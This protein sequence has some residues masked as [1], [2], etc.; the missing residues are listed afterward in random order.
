MRSWIDQMKPQA[1]P[2]PQPLPVDTAFGHVQKIIGDNCMMCHANFTGFSESDFVTNKLVMPGNASQSELYAKLIGSNVGGAIKADM[3]LK[4][5]PLSTDQLLDV[6]D[7]I[8][9]MPAPTPTATPIPSA[10]PS[11]TPSASPVSSPSPSPSP[12]ASSGTLTAAQRTSAA[13]LVISTNCAFCHGDAQTATS[14]VFNGKAVPVFAG[15]TTD[16]QFVSSGIINAGDPTRSWLIRSL[17]NFGDINTMPQ[18]SS[19]LST[20]DA[21]TLKTWI[22]G[23]GSP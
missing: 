18:E 9:Q 12:S 14:T 7:W 5:A 20:S 23:I 17:Q 16:A 6:K 1:F 2:S 8:N 19:P 21:Q 11:S 13:L 10:T 22:S 15:F 4:G 3:P